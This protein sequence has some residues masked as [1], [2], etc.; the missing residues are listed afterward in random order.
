MLPAAV[1]LRSK[2]NSRATRTSMTHDSFTKQSREDY[3]NK[4]KANNIVREL[5]TRI[6]EG[7]D[8]SMEEIMDL[9]G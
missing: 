4:I 7:E 2:E 8:V 9:T 5:L 3:N 6:D 1:Q